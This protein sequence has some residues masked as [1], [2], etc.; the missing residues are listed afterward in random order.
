MRDT[1]RTRLVLIVLLVAA[2]SLIAF[3]YTD[4]SSSVLRAMRRVAGSV[5]GG[6]EHAASSVAGF[7][8]GSRSSS[9]QV[10]KLQQEVVQLRAQLSGAQLSK[11]EYAQ[12]HKL[13]LVAGTGRYRIVPATVIAVGQGYQQTVTLNVGSRDGVR[14]NETVLNGQGL[15]G[16][17]TSVTATTATVLLAIDSSSVVGVAIAPSGELG[18]VTGPG[19]TAGP[20]WSLH[21]QMLSSAARLKPGAAL[22]TS[23]SV[24]DRPFVPG[25]PVGMITKL[26]NQA[27]S[28]TEVAEVRPFVDYSALGV[29]GVVIQPPARN[30]RFSVLPPLPRPA[31]AVT[32]TVRARP[33]PAASSSPSPSARG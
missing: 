1:R 25:V 18:Y 28:L 33:A 21:L 16:Q 15:V 29:V 20:G 4:G 26:L 27:G 30:P 6:A 14:A 10:Q 23:A 12:L 3:D 2:L 17:V 9:S 8:S 5:F 13:L 11:A 22:V 24:K 19:K 31:P 32:I 7:F